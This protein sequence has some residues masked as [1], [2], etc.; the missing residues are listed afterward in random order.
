MCTKIVAILDSSIDERKRCNTH[1]P[2]KK[3]GGVCQAVERWRE[4]RAH[5]QKSTRE[6]IKENGINWI[7]IYVKV[8]K[9]WS[10]FQS[11]FLCFE[12]NTHTHTQSNQY[13]RT[14]LTSTIA[15]FHFYFSSHTIWTLFVSGDVPLCRTN[16]HS[17]HAQTRKRREIKCWN[18]RFLWEISRF[19]TPLHISTHGVFDRELMSRWENLNKYLES[20]AV[21]E[22]VIKFCDSTKFAEMK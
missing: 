22:Y 17:P 7:I 1:Q 4:H 5:V 3:T 14:M 20:H 8:Y 11:F 18:E 21:F 16:T 13:T 15:F 19:S 6:H 2:K 9:I 10:W 12:H